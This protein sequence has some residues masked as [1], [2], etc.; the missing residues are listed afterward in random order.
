M[1]DGSKAVASFISH[2]DAA[3]RST[4]HLRILEVMHLDLLS[5][6]L[7]FAPRHALLIINFEFLLVLSGLLV[8]VHVLLV[9]VMAAKGE[10][11]HWKTTWLEK[12][13]LTSVSISRKVRWRFS[14]VYCTLSLARDQAAKAPKDIRK[15]LIKHCSIW[16]SHKVVSGRHQ[17]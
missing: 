4:T 6:R 14:P 17:H 8:H 1:D 16:V 3:Q 10:L 2:I 5:R 9:D 13:Y 7:A 12:A 15:I 11:T